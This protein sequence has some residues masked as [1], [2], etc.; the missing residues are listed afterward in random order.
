MLMPSNVQPGDTFSAS[1]MPAADAKNYD[2]VPGLTV[3]LFNAPL[4]NGQFSQVGYQGLTVG[5]TDTGPAPVEDGHFTLTVPPATVTV[6]L[7]SRQEDDPRSTPTTTN[8]SLTTPS[9]ARSNTLRPP[10]TE[11]ELNFALGYLNYLWFKVTDY[12]EEWWDAYDDGAPDWVLA[13]IDDDID[14]AQSAADRLA[15]SLPID[16]VRTMALWKAIY[17]GWLDEHYHYGTS[18]VHKDNIDYYTYR[19]VPQDYLARLIRYSLTAPPIL[20][21]GRL[22]VL[23]GNFSGDCNDTRVNVD[24]LPVRFIAS[25][26][27]DYY[28]M[29]PEEMTPGPHTLFVSNGLYRYR[30]PIFA[31]KLLM[32]I[33]TSMLHTRS[34]PKSTVWHLSLVGLNGFPASGWSGGSFSPDLVS[35]SDLGTLPEGFQPPDQTR[36]GVIVLR[37]SNLSPNIISIPELPGGQRTW[38][39][40]AQ[41]FAPKGEFDFDARADALQDG[42]FL[43]RGLAVAMLKSVVGIPERPGPPGGGKPETPSSS[44]SAQSSGKTSAQLLQEAGDAY[45]EA[46]RLAESK[47]K[48]MNKAWDN[49]CSKVPSQFRSAYENAAKGFAAA[50]KAWQNAANDYGKNPTDENRKK[51]APLVTSHSEKR[52]ALDSARQAVI[53]HMDPAARDAWR[54]AHTDYEN[55]AYHEALAKEALESAYKAA[56]SPK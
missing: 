3:K 32:S 6:S 49:A 18:V 28:F 44:A 14:S 34:F 38:V 19:A 13:E 15:L 55:S 23:R 27:T 8:L 40:D 9:W 51:I 7:V 4:P 31:M 5:T 21:V 17:E 52:L 46:Q 43:I 53:D 33:D 10:M 1:I 48:A 56:G 26:L 11:A 36:K 16:E 39:L 25:N 54:A 50:D 12:E 47:R 30:I 42:N 35:L 2:G 20:Q 41:K 37:A 29:P 45:T 22:G 24:G